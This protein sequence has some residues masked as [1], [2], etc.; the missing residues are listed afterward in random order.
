MLKDRVITIIAFLAAAVLITACG[1]AGTDAA[2]PDPASN[3]KTEANTTE[4]SPAREPASVGSLATPS[5]AYRTAFE[6]RNKKDIEG[7]KKVM[8][9]DVLEFFT[10]VGEAGGKSL[11]DMLRELAEKPQAAKPEVR[12]EKITGDRATLEYLDHDG[13]W[14]EMDFEKEDGVWKLTV[15]KMDPADLEIETKP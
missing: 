2:K 3:T 14:K 4:P 13:K 9:K 6:L 8:S 15:P 7:L 5:D 12:N 1:S 11:E 10:E